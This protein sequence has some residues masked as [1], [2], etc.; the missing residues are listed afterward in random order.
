MD[1]IDA[2]LQNNFQSSLNPHDAH[3]QAWTGQLDAMHPLVLI[4]RVR[5]AEH[6]SFGNAWDYWQ[7]VDKDTPTSQ[8]DPAPAQAAETPVPEVTASDGTKKRRHR[9]PSWATVAMPYMKELYGAGHYKSAAMFYKALV[10][11]AGESNSPFKLVNRELYCTEAGTTVS[12][13]ALGNCWPE[14]RAH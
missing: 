7:E 3:V 6:D 5:Q 4:E 13:G 9:K 11:R 2:E 12:D 8:S 1:K 10:S 14:I